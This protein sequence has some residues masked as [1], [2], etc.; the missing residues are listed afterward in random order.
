LAATACLF[1]RSALLA[2]ACF[3]VDLFWFDFGD[4]SPIILI[5]FCGLTHLRHVGFSEG[6]TIMLTGEAIVN[7][8]R[9]II[10]R[11][12]AQRLVRPKDC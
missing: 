9:E 1:F 11:V 4:L 3:C 7:G 5:F 10:W 2:L 8:G 12:T 6:K